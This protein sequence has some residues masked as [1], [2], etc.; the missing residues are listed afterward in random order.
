MTTTDKKSF[1]GAFLKFF[2][3]NWFYSLRYMR[4]NGSERYLEFLI[5]LEHLGQ[6]FREA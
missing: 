5:L 4:W 3:K 1:A 2:L 6:I